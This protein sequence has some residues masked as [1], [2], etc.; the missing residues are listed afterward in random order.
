[1]R[2]AGLHI[3]GFGIFHNLDITGLSPGLNVFLGENESGKTTLLAFLRVIL[4]GFP[5]G[6]RR[7][8]IYP[9]LAG[10]RHGGYLNLLSGDKEEYVVSRYH[11]RKRGPLTVT[12]PDGSQGD[13]EVVRQLTGAATE[14][15]FRSV[16]AFSL[17][18][19]QRFES[20]KK[21]EVKAAIYS[22]GAGVGK[23]S[24]AQIEKG[25]E[26]SIGRLYKP[27]GK[28]QQSILFLESCR[29]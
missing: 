12:L 10:G 28:I 5:P 8:N 19:L 15:L 24:I 13:A 23:I 17:E 2:L 7:E 29:R 18:E 27:G 26:A 25:L 1:M 3:D 21:Q 9:P 11:G 4:F 14:D 16:F 6:Q 22:A 20:L